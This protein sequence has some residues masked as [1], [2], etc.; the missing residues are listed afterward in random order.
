MIE[1]I[2]GE[3]IILEALEN[4]DAKCLTIEEALDFY[5]KAKARINSETR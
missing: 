4:V 1:K 5:Q 3:H 2:T